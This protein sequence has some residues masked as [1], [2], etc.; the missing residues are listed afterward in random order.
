MDIPGT[1]IDSIKEHEGFRG[2][3]YLDHIGN[4]TIGYGTLLPITME[5]AELLLSHRLSAMIREL[6]AAK[7]FIDGLP[8]DAKIVLLEMAYQLG[9]PKLLGFQRM[10][11][12]IER[13]YFQGA[14]DEMLDSRWYQQTPHR[15]RALSDRMKTA[16]YHV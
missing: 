9:V 5:E 4:P 3:Q 13:G 14:G 6:Q 2:L 7:P 8:L 1:V 10:W 11:A 12:A 16:T 15:A